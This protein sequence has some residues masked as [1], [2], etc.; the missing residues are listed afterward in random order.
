MRAVM[1]EVPEHI[2]EWRRRTGAD[3]RDE[4]WEGVLHMSPAPSNAHQ[5][6]STE[7][8][9]WLVWHLGFHRALVVTQEINVAR[10]GLGSDWRR[11]YRVPD[12]T[13]G[14]RQGRA[15]IDRGTHCE[16]A[17]E[18]VIEIRSPGD[19]SDDKAPFYFEAG[20]L[21]V[22]IIDRDTRV[23][24]LHLRGEHGF[25]RAPGEDGGW[26]VSPFTTVRLSEVAGRLVVQLGDDES[27]RKELPAG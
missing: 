23:P 17:P 15:E 13:L 9:A 4:M 12:V 6:L 24:E 21:E 5:Q 10:P 16:G 18:V 3:R 19:E 11:D 20:A 22:W 7:L 26:V 2:L 27:T 8:S 14:S 1:L 25:E